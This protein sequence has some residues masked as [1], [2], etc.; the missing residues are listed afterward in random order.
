[1]CGH[2]YASTLHHYAN[3]YWQLGLY[4]ADTTCTCVLLINSI[5]HLPLPVC[6][7]NRHHCRYHHVQVVSFVLD[8]QSRH[9]NAWAVCDVGA[10]IN[11]RALPS[12]LTEEA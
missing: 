1:L 11:S 5:D 2:L 10:N 3:G 4:L 8:A 9:F 7:C 12:I 6:H